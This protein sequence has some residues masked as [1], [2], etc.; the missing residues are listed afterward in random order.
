MYDLLEEVSFPFHGQNFFSRL[1]R[2]VRLL[3]FGKLEPHIFIGPKMLFSFAHFLYIAVKF[4]KEDLCPTPTKGE[5][6]GTYCFW[7]GSCWRQRDSF[8]CAQYLVN[9]FADFDQICMDITLG[10]DEEL[11]RFW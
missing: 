7:C 2:R 3:L 10:H 4:D 1:G 9:Q 6:R 5:V 11:I 8:L